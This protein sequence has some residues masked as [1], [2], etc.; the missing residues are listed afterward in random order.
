MVCTQDYDLCQAQQQY[1]IYTWYLVRSTILVEA[2]MMN[3]CALFPPKAATARPVSVVL[4]TYP[5]AVERETL[6][7][8]HRQKTKFIA[9]ESRQMKCGRTGSERAQEFCFLCCVETQRVPLT[10]LAPSSL[11]GMGQFL[12]PNSGFLAV[13]CPQNPGIHLLY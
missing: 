9:N 1:V 6:S 8:G 5:T 7:C 12:A 11:G 2:V 13:S 3:I 10:F 4:I